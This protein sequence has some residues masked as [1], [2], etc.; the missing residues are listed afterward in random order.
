M[1][2]SSSSAR[3]RGCTTQ[4]RLIN[5][6]LDDQGRGERTTVKLTAAG[7]FTDSGAGWAA[8]PARLRIFDDRFVAT[9]ETVHGKRGENLD[10]V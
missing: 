3:R 5:A 1:T 6:L 7:C 9:I 4:G 8:L 2:W 10:N